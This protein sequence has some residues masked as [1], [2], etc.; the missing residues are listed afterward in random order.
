MPRSDA[1]RDRLVSY[2]FLLPPTLL[3]LILFT[4]GGVYQL[5]FAGHQMQ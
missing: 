2:F 1:R 5:C 3:P 4:F